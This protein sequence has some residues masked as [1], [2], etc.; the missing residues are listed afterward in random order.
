MYVPTH[1]AQT[2]PAALFELI[3]RFP[4]AVLVTDGCDGLRAT[5]LP[6]LHDP[7]PEPHGTLLCHVA[8]ANPQWRECDGGAEAL[9]IFSG[10][11]AYVSPSW[12]EGKATV[13]T[14]DYI[15]V[16]AYG[17]LRAIDDPERLRRLVTHL[18]QHFEAERPQPWTVESQP[19]EYIERMVHGIVGLE[20]PITRIFGAWKLS[21]NR[22]N[23][24]REGVERALLASKAPRDREVAAEMERVRDF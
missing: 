8:R 17:P 7:E 16:H 19:A 2:D 4:F 23:A 13:P 3:E 5:H 18:T 24:D 12:Y 14:W 1:F 11:D 22:S 20:M 9:A 10:P 15:A 6:I 21:Q